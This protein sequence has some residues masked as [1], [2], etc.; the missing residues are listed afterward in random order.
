MSNIKVYLTFSYVLLAS[1]LQA[2]DFAKSRFRQMIELNTSGTGA[3]LKADV[4]NFPVA[5]SLND[6]NFNFSEANSN[7]SDLRFSK[8]KDTGLLVHSVEHW[9]KETKTALIWVKMDVSGNKSGQAIFMHWGDVAAQDMTD[10]KGVFS[11]KEGFVSVWHLNESGD[12][13][14]N[15]YKDATASAA[16]GTGINIKKGSAVNGR[17]G[18]G[19]ALVNAQKEW[20]RIDAGDRKIFDLTNKMT[21]SIWAM[22]NS[23][24]NKGG[25]ETMFAKGDNSWR[26]QKFGIKS[27]HNPP[28]DLI[29]ICVEEPPHADLCLVGKTDMV[30]KKWFHFVAVHDYPSLKLYV[31]GVLDNTANLQTNWI[32]DNHP[33][34]I[35]NQSQFPG[36]GRSWDGILDEARVYNIPKDDNW[37]KLE[38]ESQK[39]G[40][41]FWTLK[42]KEIKF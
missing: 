34:G 21:F 28:A 35:G 9:D 14:S 38:Y 26:L 20:I 39:E 7:G 29:E 36:N 1:A 18:R 13:L 25:Y 16:H 30:P 40:Q 5:I 37:I 23:Y 2:Q 19:A 4:Y 42:E 33:V 32:S 17:L 15:H 3:N 6:K 10:S 41:L 24:P 8:A 12:T 27:W 22:A 31:N 11:N